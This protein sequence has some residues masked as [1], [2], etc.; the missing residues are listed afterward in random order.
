[1]LHRRR[2]GAQEPCAALGDGS[3]LSN[4][5]F[6]AA[7]ALLALQAFVQRDGDCAGHGLAGQPGQLAG[8]PA[9]LLVL[10]VEA[11]RPSMVEDDCSC[12]PYGDRRSNSTEVEHHVA[13]DVRILSRGRLRP[14]AELRRHR[15]G[16]RGARAPGGV[17]VRPGLRRGLRGLRLRGPPGE[18]LRA[19]AARADGEVLGGLHQRA[20]P[21]LPQGADRPD[22]QLRQGVLGG[23]RRQREVGREGS[24]G[25]PRP[26]RA[27]HG[28]HRQRDP[29][30]RHQALRQALGADHLLLGERDRGRGDPAAPVRL[31][32][33]RRGPATGRSASASTRSSSR[34]TTT[35]T[36]S[37]PRA[38]RTRTRSASSSRRHRT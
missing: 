11:H 32:R 36:R 30:P 19:H 14:R 12:L 10:D 29:V 35:S 8:E 1:M 38:G 33:E 13:E 28:L 5:G 37:W 3:K 17:P 16:R 2:P 18:P 27:R 6:D 21:E 22:R 23:D 31:R 26:H 24:P 20:H 25:R 15:P 7:P 34:S 4:A 9:G